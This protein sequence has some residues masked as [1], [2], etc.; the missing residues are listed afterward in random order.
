MNRLRSIS[1]VCTPASSTAATIR[2][3]SGT[4]N[5]SGFSRIR[6]LP[7]SAACGLTREGTL[8]GALEDAWLAVQLLRRLHGLAPVPMRLHGI[9]NGPAFDEAAA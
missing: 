1:S 5:A 4:V 3:A 8:H 9:T 2:S 7:A 6:C